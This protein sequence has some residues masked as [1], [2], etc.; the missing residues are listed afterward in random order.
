MIY[1]T[2]EAVPASSLADIIHTR[3]L[4]ALRAD[5]ERAVSNIESDPSAAVTAASS[6]LES[7]FRIYIEEHALELPSKETIGSLWSVVQRHLKIHPSAER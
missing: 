6:I 4:P 2:A 1:G 5:F 7:I 3:D